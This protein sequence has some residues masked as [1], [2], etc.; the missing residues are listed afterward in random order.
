MYKINL[1]VTSYRL[2][3]FVFAFAICNLQSVIC[4]SQTLINS[5]YSR[6]GLGDLQ[7]SGFVNSIPMGGIYNALQNDTTAPFFVN[8]SNPASHAS[9]KLTI[10]DLGVRSNTTQLQTTDNKF[11]SNQTTLAYMALAFP[12]AKWWGACISLLPYSNVGYNIFTQTPPNAN[13][14]AISY[15]YSGSGGI[16]Q[17]CFGNGFRIKHFYIGANVSYLFGD[18]VFASNDSFPS[19]SNNFNTKFLQTTR[20]SDLYYSFGMQYRQ[21][22]KNNWSFTL[23]ATGGF[24]SDLSVQRTD[25]AYSYINSFGIEVAKDTAIKPVAVKDNITIPL[26]LG[27]GIVVKKG[28]KFL[29]GVDYSVQDW[30]AFDSFGQQGLLKNSERMSV[31][32]QYIPN[33]GA[34]SKESYA[35]KIFYRAGFRYTDTYLDLNNTALKDYAFTFGAGLPLRKYKVGETYSQSIINVGFEIGQKGTTDNTLIR[36]RYVNV[37]LSFTLNDRLFIKRKYD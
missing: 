20:V 4:N 36:Q 10:F 17:V 27:G 5:P 15:T 18:L 7:S 19:G 6:Y 21:Q 13:L 12:V 24:K 16:N 9:S 8:V 1:Q 11:T 25:F 35:K 30:S 14:G 32:A 26:S 37:F 28:D 2:K 23:G 22:L 31:G 29:L 33:K 34:G 3:V